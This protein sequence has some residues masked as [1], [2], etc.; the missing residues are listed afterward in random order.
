MTL[1]SL[2]TFSKILGL[3]PN[4][5][6]YKENTPEHQKCI[7]LQE[8]ASEMLDQFY[9]DNQKLFEKYIEQAQ[10]Q[11]VIDFMN[12]VH[13]IYNKMDDDICVDMEAL[14]GM[15]NGFNLE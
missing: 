5:K 2:I 6:N 4:C 8:M 3:T 13:H 12:V 1:L 10:K 7:K 15:I 11:E 14:N 9:A